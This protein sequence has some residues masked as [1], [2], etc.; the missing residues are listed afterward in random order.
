MR[1]FIGVVLTGYTVTYSKVITQVT[2]HPLDSYWGVPQCSIR[3]IKEEKENIVVDIVFPEQSP[4]HFKRVLSQC[5]LCFLHK[6]KLGHKDKFWVS[7][8]LSAKWKTA[9]LTFSMFNS[10]LVDGEFP[11]LKSM[12]R[13]LTYSHQLANKK[14]I[15]EEPHS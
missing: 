8:A 5:S 6:E 2:T 1:E 11:I 10:C 3:H 15:T 14:S 7:H 4:L 12:V 13:H 9:P